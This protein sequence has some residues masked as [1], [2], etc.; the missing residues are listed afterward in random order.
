M[1]VV[2]LVASREI[3]QGEELTTTYISLTAGRTTGDLMLLFGISNDPLLGTQ[4]RRSLLK[5]GW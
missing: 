2:R 5:D 3:E 1:S 4:T